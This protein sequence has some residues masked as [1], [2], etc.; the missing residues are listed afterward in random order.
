[1]QTDDIALVVAV[2]LVLV[3]LAQSVHQP[4]VDDDPLSRQETYVATMIYPDTSSYVPEPR[5]PSVIDRYQYQMDHRQYSDR[6]GSPEGYVARS[7]PSDFHLRGIPR[8]TESNTDI[9]YRYYA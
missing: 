9:Q 1:M 8:Y 3:W 5:V 6:R 4:E 2:V 7:Q